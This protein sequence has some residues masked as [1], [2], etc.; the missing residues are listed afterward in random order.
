MKESAKLHSQPEAQMSYF[1]AHSDERQNST[2]EIL[3]V[4]GLRSMFSLLL[5]GQGLFSD[6]KVCIQVLRNMAL[7][8]TWQ[9]STSRPKGIRLLSF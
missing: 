8:V 4:T 6:P 9:F 5:A 1:Q 2:V 3:T 7:S